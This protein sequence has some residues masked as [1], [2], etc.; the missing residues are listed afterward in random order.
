MSS[1]AEIVE[2][3]A[4]VPWLS[5]TDAQPSVISAG[6][7][8]PAWSATTWLNACTTQTEWFVFVAL[9]NASGGT[10]AAASEDAIDD[11]ATVL[12]PIGKVVRVEPWRIPV[13]QGQQTIPVCRF[14]LEA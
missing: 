5:A 13:E 4:K 3:L 12:W 7:A 14:T 9:P 8:W 2:A 10:T 1:H 6:S 11:V